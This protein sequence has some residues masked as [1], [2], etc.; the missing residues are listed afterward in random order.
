MH[1]PAPEVVVPVGVESEVDEQLSESFCITLR[2]D[3]VLHTTCEVLVVDYKTYI[4][5]GQQKNTA[6]IG[7]QNTAIYLYFNRKGFLIALE[8]NCRTL[9]AG[10]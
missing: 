2:P 6:L 4:A 3:T 1:I 7:L 5:G 10:T 9:P 8:T